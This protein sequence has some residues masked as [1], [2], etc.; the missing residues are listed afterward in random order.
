MKTRRIQWRGGVAAALVA[1]GMMWAPELSL[2][3]DTGGEPPLLKVSAASAQYGTSRRVAR[4]TT[5]RTSRRHNAWDNDVAVA[6]VATGAYVTT[7]PVGC[8]SVLLSG[9]T[10]QRCGSTYYRPYMQGDQVVYVVEAPPQ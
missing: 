5:R 2:V 1:L 3:S 9:I 7:L 8:G 4:R 6:G 10:Y